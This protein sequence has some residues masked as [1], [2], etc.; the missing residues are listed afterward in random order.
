MNEDEWKLIMTGIGGCERHQELLCQLSLLRNPEMMSGENESTF[1]MDE[2]EILSSYISMWVETV[3]KKIILSFDD[4]M[5]IWNK[6]LDNNTKEKIRLSCFKK[7][8]Q[9]GDKKSH[10]HIFPRFSKQMRVFSFLSA[11]GDDHAYRS[12]RGFCSLEDF[13]PESRLLNPK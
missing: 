11:S 1:S 9:R 5:L 3:A 7:V 4:S 10:Y 2:D 13:F 12:N 6:Q 8:D